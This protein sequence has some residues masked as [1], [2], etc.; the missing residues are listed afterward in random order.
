MLLLLLC[1]ITPGET[2]AEEYQRASEFRKGMMDSFSAGP[3]SFAQ[4]YE[5]HSWAE[6][7]PPK[8]ADGY[9]YHAASPRR[10]WISDGPSLWEEGQV[11]FAPP[12]SQT[13]AGTS[14][15][16]DIIVIFDPGQSTVADR[17]IK[18]C[19]QSESISLMPSHVFHMK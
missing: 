10:I 7:E 9:A 8:R 12:P 1:Q 2:Y 11:V 15:Q 5:Y 3:R 4:A 14:P 13:V 6:G 19:S 18:T 16:V 17:K